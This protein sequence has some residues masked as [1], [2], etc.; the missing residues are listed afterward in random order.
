MDPLCLDPL[1]DGHVHT[2]YSDGSASAEQ[3]VRAAVARGL[4]SLAVTD[5][6][7]LPEPRR[8][9]MDIERIGAYRRE[10]SGLRDAYRGRITVHRGL[11][12]DYLPEEDRW[13]REMAAMGWD[14]LVGSVHRLRTDGGT[15]LINGHRGEFAR[16]V[17]EGFGGSARRLVE[18]YFATL[19][20]LIRSGLCDVVG[21]FDVVK[22][23][24]AG[25]ADFDEAQPWY[26]DAVERTLEAVAAAGPAVE[27]NTGG[28][29]QPAAAPYPS[30]WIVEACRR[31]R[32]PLVLGSDAHRPDR[33]GAGFV[34]VTGRAAGE[35]RPPSTAGTGS[36]RDAAR[37]SQGPP[38]NDPGL[39]AD[40]AAGV[41]GRGA[42]SG[43]SP[44]VPARRASAGK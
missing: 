19:R 20:R 29:F 12:L 23:H 36:C 34:R 11:E 18:A 3:M 43:S 33:V 8:Y 10:L 30:P 16:A 14:R 2:L 41:P 44:P 24:L 42:G 26:R 28:L 37:E 17:A 40:P 31:R 15:W 9:A 21:H 7:P 39:V 5:H 38:E 13:C 22:K 25:R 35:Q 4:V 32:I 27:I 1:Q 6:M